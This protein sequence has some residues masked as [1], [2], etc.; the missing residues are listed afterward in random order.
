MRWITGRRTKYLILLLWAALAL[1]LASHASEIDEV[2]RNDL[3]QFTPAAAESSRVRDLVAR[4]SRGRDL[5]AVVVFARDGGLT[6]ADRAAVD[7]AVPGAEPVPSADGAAAMVVVPI[8]AASEDV[9]YQRVKDLR[10]RVREGLPA[11]LTVAVTGPA[12][13]Y[14]DGADAFVEADLTLLLVT[15]GVVAVFLIVIYRGPLLW[16][17]PFVAVVLSAGM[18]QGAVTLLARHA[19]LVVNGMS[20]G[21]LTALVFGAG[22]DYALLLIAR[23]REELHRTEDRHEAMAAALRGALPAVTASAVTVAAG[24]LCLLVADMRS[25]A[26]L[27]P[28]AAVG[29]LCTF[30]TVTMLL[31]VLLLVCGRGAFWPFIP[32]PGRRIRH[33]VWEGVGRRVARRPRAVWLVT[34]AVLAALCLPLTGAEAGIPGSDAYTAPP[35]S[36]TGQRLVSAHFPAGASA[37]AEVLVRPADRGR[38]AAVAAGVTGVAAVRQ[39][40]AVGDLAGLRVTLADPPESAAAERTVERLRAALGGVPG[41]LV[42]GQT[43][44]AVD[45]AAAQ[46]HDLLLVV[47]LVLLVTLA[48]L[49]ALL[50]SLVAPLLLTA[51]VVL[52]FGAVLGLGW[53]VFHHLLGFPALGYD[54]IL[55]G[56]VFLVALGVDYNIFLTGRIRE[57]TAV[58]GDHRRGVLR[59][60]SLTGSVITGAGLILAA[61][62]SALTILPLV[63]AVQ[64]GVLVAL[65]VLLDTFA[66]RSV[67]VPALLLDLGPHSWWPVRPGARGG[68]VAGRRTDEAVG[69]VPGRR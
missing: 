47:P 31:P 67:L 57:E 1:P 22:T 55:L 10:Q 48:V 56:F 52:S 45:T 65:G 4:S 63:W 30:L 13:G 59:G 29:V 20:S 15:V 35:E 39:D 19:G 38:A 6:P 54:A 33:G 34:V 5:P 26:S 11:G 24:V 18:S 50:R 44:T 40:G 17:P 43:A 41:A 9:V 14:V 28:V 58:G 62:F 51:T 66:V 68:G 53:T 21:V 8:D 7:A 25:S 64:F 16:L 2:M 23:Y 49:V 69:P 27:G 37:P 3:T 46:R 36:I 61:T 32:R 60:L 42:G 12:G